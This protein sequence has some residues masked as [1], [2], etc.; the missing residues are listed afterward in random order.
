MHKP[1]ILIVEDDP[2]WQCLYQQG[3]DGFEVLSATSV[4]VARDLFREH[5]GDV[6]VIVLDGYM[7]V[8]A[9]ER[10]TLQ[11]AKDVRMAGFE[12]PMFA[13]SGD[14]HLSSQLMEAGCTH[15]ASKDQVFD[16][17][18]DLFASKKVA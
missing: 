8:D 6:A 16:L 4:A 15:R 13:S 5:A 18:D 3:L 10:T 14:P 2:T 9:L 17:I 11:F 1:K 12:G 7:G